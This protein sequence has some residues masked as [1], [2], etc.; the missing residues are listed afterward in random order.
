M[1]NGRIL[2]PWEKE[3]ILWYLKMVNSHYKMV[4][5]LNHKKKSK[6]Y[7]TKRF[8]SSWPKINWVRYMLQ[9]S[10]ILIKEKN[11]Q[12]NNSETT[13]ETKWYLTTDL[14]W[15]YPQTRWIHWTRWLNSCRS[16]STSIL[17]SWPWIFGMMHWTPFHRS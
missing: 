16:C 13:S 12:K 6:K 1:W 8:I 17:F 5:T 2:R 14:S 7:Y 15:I 3:Y 10:S 11:V 4:Y 9:K